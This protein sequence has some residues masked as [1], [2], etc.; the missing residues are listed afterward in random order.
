MSAKG[1][2]PRALV[3]AA[4]LLGAAGRARA[5]APQETA[6]F[7]A[8]AQVG[9]KATVTIN[10][11]NLQGATAV[12]ISGQGVVAKIANNTNAGALPLE[13]TVAPDAK[14]GPRELRVVTPRGTSNARQI[15]VDSYPR[16]SETEPN[17]IRSQA[18]VLSKFPVTI[19]GQ[20]NGAEDVD[21]FAFDVGA[22]ET[23][24]FDLNGARHRSSIDGYLSLQDAEGR[25]LKTV[26]EVSDHDP[27][28]AYTFPK[29]GRYYLQ[30]RDKLYRGGADYTYAVNAGRLP[31]V[32]ATMP[33]GG[34]RGESVE[35]SLEGVNLGDMKTMRVQMPADPG[36]ATLTVVPA[37]QAGPANPVLLYAG[38]LPETSEIEPNDTIAQA[39]RLPTVPVVVNG[40]IGKDRDVDLFAFTG[41]PNQP[42][43][44]EVWARRLSSRMDSILRILDK[45]GKEL[46]A[47]D[48]AIGKDSRIAFT[49]PAAGNYFAEVRSLDNHGG[50]GYFYRLEI[51]SPPP[52][53]FS[54]TVTPDNAN[55]GP[56]GSVALTV[57]CQRAGYNGEIAVRVEGL[58]AG[59]AAS[60]ANIRAGQNQAL[61]SLTAEGNAAV[62]AGLIRVVGEATIDGKQVARVA[63]PAEPVQRQGQEQP[64]QRTVVMQVASVTEQQAYALQLEPRQLTI[65]QGE[66][67]EITLRALR[68]A[69]FKAAI[70][71]AVLANLLPPGVTA[72]VKP[73]PQDQSEVKFNLVAAANAAPATQN[74]VFTG[75]ANNVVQSSPAL[76]VTIAPK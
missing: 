6:V 18:M 31:L 24:V 38:D 21:W 37:A 46:A 29:A 40:R 71:V 56:N 44:F 32:T 19:D 39:T 50:P 60:P 16:V 53:D 59:V 54:L 64:T 68:K 73:V 67:I 74:I 51:K 20:A 45:D 27:C 1:F 48:D 41:Q 9:A 12:L 14:P 70:N 8:G 30:V 2:V 63:Q 55:I 25:D 58:P 61:M 66:T 15:Y 4:L 72:Q 34:R 69:D 62:A 3:C 76:A 33:L 28:L 47:N 5:Q 26:M 49:P 75:N 17:N 52:P 23:W 57:A 13:L 11:A 42:L 10:G 7:P 35:V 43:V 65:K 22:G 36:L